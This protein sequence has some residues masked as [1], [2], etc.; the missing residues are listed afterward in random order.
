[1]CQCYG[2]FFTDAE[3]N[4]LN[5]VNYVSDEWAKYGLTLSASGQEGNLPRLFDTANP[6][7]QET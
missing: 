2:E 4:P 7:S 5:P 6:G 3:G 1:M